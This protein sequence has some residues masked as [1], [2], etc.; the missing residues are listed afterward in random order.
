MVLR[1]MIPVGHS[2]RECSLA[3]GIPADQITQRANKLGLKFSLA[4]GPESKCRAGHKLQEVGYTMVTSP[5]SGRHGRRCAICYGEK[6]RRQ[7]ASKRKRRGQPS[8]PSS[9]VRADDN[10]TQRAYRAALSTN[11]I[12]LLGEQIDREPRKWIRDEL[13]VQLVELTKSLRGKT[14]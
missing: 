9:L 14:Q 6:K 8:K 11:A 4:F 10:A 13:T 2:P 1:H 7:V 3:I 12:L 5:K